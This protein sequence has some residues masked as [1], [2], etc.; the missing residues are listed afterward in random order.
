MRL[1]AFGCMRCLWAWY[2][3]RDTCPSCGEPDLIEITP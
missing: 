1:R 3:S 2:G